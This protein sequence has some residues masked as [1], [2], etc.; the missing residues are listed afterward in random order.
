MAIPKFGSNIA[1]MIKNLQDQAM[2]LSKNGELNKALGYAMKAYN[3]AKQN[4]RTLEILNAI[5]IRLNDFDKALE[6]GLQTLKVDP[7]NLNAHD[8]LAHAYGAKRDWQNCGKY[9][10]VALILRDELV[11]KTIKNTPHLPEI[12]NPQKRTK[13]IISF[14]LFGNNPYYCEPSILNARLVNEIYPNDWVCRFYVDESVSENTLKRLREYG[15]QIIIADD[16]M[17]KIPKTLWRFLAADDNDV[18]RVVFRDADS[19]ISEREAWCVSQWE[20]S[21]KMFHI[22]RDGSSH[23][24]LIMAG[25]WGIKAGALN[26][27][28]L[29]SEYF[30]TAKIDGRYDDQYFLRYKIWQFAKQSLLTHDRIFDFLDPLPI[31][32]D[33][34]FDYS[35][36]HIGCCEGNGSIDV[37]APANVKDGTN[38]TWGLYTKILPKLDKNLQIVDGGV[39]YLV[40]EYDSVVLNRKITFNIPI[41]YA[42]G[43]SN[44][45]SRVDV[46]VKQ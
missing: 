1:I 34:A 2:A 13:N 20:Q 40:C 45:L 11:S 33:L 10:K 24:E 43:F 30:K 25:T 42:K 9:G 8:T 5:T 18:L 3:I 16:E 27:K 23:T 21:D 36:G 15:A 19:I 12:S 31:A 6:F 44:G 28:E 17:R 46:K 22:I 7:K 39:W 37:N 32:P 14:T 26:M 4:L 38:V 35:I 41:R 29:M